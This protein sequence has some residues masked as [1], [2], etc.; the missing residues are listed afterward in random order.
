MP[1]PTHKLKT[2]PSY[3]Q[4]VW[5]GEKT[6]EVRLDD[7]GYQ[8]GDG[9]VL[10]EWDRTVECSCGH[11]DHADI[12]AKYSGRTI[13]ARIGHVMASTPPRGSVRGF[14]GNGYVVFSLCDPE[15]HVGTPGDLTV[16]V[17]T[18]G[19]DRDLEAL[20]RVAAASDRQ[21]ARR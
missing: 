5:T 15:M 7:R 6:F 3:F 14:S 20:R 19:S 11:G 16:T 1:C 17:T 21:A 2:W 12:C 10:R 4:R 13:T 8:K 18:G 9:V